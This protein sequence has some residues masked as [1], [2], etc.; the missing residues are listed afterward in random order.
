MGATASVASVTNNKVTRTPSGYRS[1]VLREDQLFLDNKLVNSVNRFCGNQAN[2]D[3]FLAFVKTGDWATKIN[4]ERVLSLVDN[5][6]TDDDCLRR[7]DLKIDAL[8]SMPPGCAH[9][10]NY[11]V[12]SR[13]RSDS[14]R[15]KA[16]SQRDKDH[17]RDCDVTPNEDD[18]ASGGFSSDSGD[19]VSHVSRKLSY[20]VSESALA[21][22]LAQIL[23]LYLKRVDEEDRRASPDIF[24]EA[25]PLRLHFGGSKSRVAPAHSDT[26][27]EVMDIESEL[28]ERKK[29]L[30]L[31]ARLRASDDT[32]L[33]LICSPRWISEI[34]N[35]IDNV[36]FSVCIASARKELFGFPVIYANHAFA[37]LSGFHPSEIIGKSCRLIQS[38]HTEPAQIDQ[39]RE[40]L[41]TAQPL[42]VAL[43]NV[44]RTGDEFVNLLTMQP[45]FNA[46]GEYTYVLAVQYDMSRPSRPGA[47]V[48]ADI[49]QVE[50]LMAVIT[51]TMSMQ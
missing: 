6:F 36:P 21:L 7:G 8:Y 17:D 20:E 27:T 22:L 26:C 19:P 11:L 13:I 25:L 1:K 15:V 9:M 40:A 23:S 45:I 42:K 38:D 34:Q 50:N 10:I 41:R 4:V 43:T 33:R 48:A 24:R 51:S 18:W 16:A 35:A 29:Q 47:S 3:S 14:S 2:C 28:V 32:I 30:G 44:H 49:R 12:T 31:F 37:E 39:I 46:A 5:T